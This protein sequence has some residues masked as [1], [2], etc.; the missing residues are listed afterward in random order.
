[1]RQNG[2]GSQNAAHLN[3]LEVG[4]TLKQC[5]S[6]AWLGLACC[7]ETEDT[8]SKTSSIYFHHDWVDEANKRRVLKGEEGEEER[9]RE[10]KRKKGKSER[11]RERGT[12]TWRKVGHYC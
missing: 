9:D 12:T 8:A 11:G 7:G 3:L 1:M 2:H 5:V 4:W 6:S 10:E